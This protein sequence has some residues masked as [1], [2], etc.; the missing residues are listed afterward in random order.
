MKMRFFQVLNYVKSGSLVCGDWY[1]RNVGY[2]SEI[3]SSHGFRVALCARF[4][5]RIAA[6]AHK[7]AEP[8]ALSE[9]DSI[10]WCC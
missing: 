1:D 2:L 8:V 7:T 9:R 5:L 10:G 4:E 3:F 6:S